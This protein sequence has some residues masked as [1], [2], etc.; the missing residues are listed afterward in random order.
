M[1]LSGRRELLAWALGSRALVIGSA[2][3][4]HRLHRPQG[5]FP[6]RY[7]AFDS[8]NH[9]LG[10][11]DGEWYRRIALHG[12]VFHAHE[13]SS[14]AFFPLYPLA[15]RLVHLFGPDLLLSGL[16]VANACFVVAVLAFAALTRELFDADTARRAAIWLCVFPLGFVFSMEYPTSMLLAAMVLASLAALHNRWLLCAVF[17]AVACLTR[18]EGAVLLVPLGVLAWRRREDVPL[19][20]GVAAL[21]VAP[22]AVASFPVYLWI[23][24]DNLHVWADS[25]REWGREFHPLGIWDAFARFG[26]Q[27]ALHPWHLRDMVFLIVYALLLALAPRAGVGWEWILAA[28][29]LVLVPLTSGTVESVAR[30]GLVGFAFYWTLAREVRRPWLEG[31]LQAGCLALMVWWVLALPLANP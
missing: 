4:L 23:R 19:W 8:T 12:Y 21:A 27:R 3:L 1:R 26:A 15:M 13:Q 29:L 31:A 22:L 20:H 7:D 18:P 30:F 16:L 9:V 25:Q 14:T 24:F 2:Y 6:D 17:L 28:G 5:Y 11:W 10:T